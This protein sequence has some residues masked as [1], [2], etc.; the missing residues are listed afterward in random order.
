[1]SG[2]R[3]T[4]RV[5]L[6]DFTLTV[7][8]NSVHLLN[9]FTCCQS[10]TWF[11]LWAFTLVC[12]HNKTR[13]GHFDGHQTPCCPQ[14]WVCRLNTGKLST[15]NREKSSII[16]LV[17]KVDWVLSVQF[18]RTRRSAKCKTCMWRMTCCVWLR[19]REHHKAEKPEACHLLMS[20]LAQ[21]HLKTHTHSFFAFKSKIHSSALTLTPFSCTR[22]SEVL[23]VDSTGDTYLVLLLPAPGLTPSSS[24]STSLLL[25]LLLLQL[26]HPAPL[27]L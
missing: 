27:Q 25:I 13:R 4:S 17:L 2:F 26:L 15:V 24:S 7:V 10:W 22:T 14:N 20:E 5:S 8:Q 23:R 16:Q 21:Q 1:M 12:F 11:S 19:D 18:T 3:F 6:R 9:T